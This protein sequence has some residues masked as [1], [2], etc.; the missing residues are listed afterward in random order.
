[1]NIQ[2][3]WLQVAD[4]TMRPLVYVQIP[5]VIETIKEAQSQ[6]DKSKPLEGEA[7]IKDIIN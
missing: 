1:M 6:I 2:L 4:A 5:E 3:V 7:Q